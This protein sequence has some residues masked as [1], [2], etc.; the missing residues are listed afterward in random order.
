MAPPTLG[1]WR[2]CLSSGGPFC[3][4]G[5]PT[6]RPTGRLVHGSWAPGDQD[7]LKA[8]SEPTVSH[9]PSQAVTLVQE[10]ETQT[11]PPT[12]Q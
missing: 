11:P 3:S 6:C 7:L 8:G 10:E 9:A 2:G 12:S 4:L 5:A 1:A